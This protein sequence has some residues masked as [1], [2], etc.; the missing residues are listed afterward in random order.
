MRRIYLGSG[1][2]QQ[3]NRPVVT[4]VKAANG[5]PGDGGRAASL[6]LR[7]HLS[8]RVNPF[9]TPIS[10]ANL[11]AQFSRTTSQRQ[12]DPFEQT[13]WMLPWHHGGNHWLLVVI[14]LEEHWISV[15]DSMLGDSQ[16]EGGSRHENI[17]RVSDRL[18]LSIKSYIL[19]D[20]VPP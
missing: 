19:I 5:G 8:E 17:H 1:H 16:R 14:D 15:L 10:N 20:L 4:R 2:L 7:H 13:L 18:S 11:R 6:L 3:S 12:L 9:C